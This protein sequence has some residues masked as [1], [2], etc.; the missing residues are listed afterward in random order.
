MLRYSLLRLLVFLGCV[1]LLWLV[2]LRDRDE[3]SAARRRRRPA[4]GGH[5]VLR[6][7]PVPRGLLGAARAQDRGRGRPRSRRRSP[8]APPTRLAEDAEVVRR[9]GHLPLSRV[10]S[11]SYPEPMD[12]EFSGEV[13]FWRGPAPHHFVSV[14]DELCGGIEDASSLVTYGWGMMP[15]T[16]RLGGSTGRRRCGPRTVATSCRCASTCAGASRSTSATRSRRPDDRR[17]R[18]DERRADPRPWGMPLVAA[19]LLVA[20]CDGSGSGS[21]SAAAPAAGRVTTTDVALPRGRRARGRHAVG[22][23]PAG[24]LARP[25]GVGLAAP[26]DRARPGGRF[27]RGRGHP[28]VADGLP[29]EVARGRT[30]RR[31]PSTS[32]VAPRPG[33]T[34]TPGG[35]P[36]AAT[37][38]RVRELP[39][40][41]AT[42]GG[43]GAG[44]LVSLVQTP[45]AP[46][47]RRV[48]G[49]RRRRA[50]HRP[51]AP[52]RASAGCGPPRPARRWRARPPTL[53]SARGATADR[54]G[55]AGRRLG[56]PARRTAAS[57]SGRRC[58]GRRARTARGRAPTCRATARWARPTRRPAT[59]LGRC[60]VVGAVD[61]TLRGWTLAADGTV[62]ALAAARRSPW[63]STTC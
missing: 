38:P 63:G 18:A 1:S 25:R 8:A 30:P 46:G 12:L 48:V 57:A 36:G 50:R 61:G 15:V 29:G 26:A 28:G 23:G 42:F 2:G 62:A 11:G 22:R 52:A 39:Q 21:D 54:D 43:W 37:P 3:L 19:L 27:A 14:P 6:A 49:E 13:W 45:S 7:A 58:G 35:S 34:P 32:S 20:A 31:P 47:R 59:T 4:L 5:L 55:R 40:P 56:D 60:T 51:L 16:V 10:G 33:P 44:A 9:R 24:R 17:L 41:F 53:V